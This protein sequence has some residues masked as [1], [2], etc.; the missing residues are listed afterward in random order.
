MIK[1]FFRSN[2]GSVSIYFI[3]TLSA[4][5]L[6]NAV[7]ID[8]ARIKAAEK[9]TEN[10]VRAA[11]RSTLS[12]FDSSLHSYGLYGLADFEQGDD[13]FRNILKRN[14]SD[15]SGGDS[16]RLIQPKWDEKSIDLQPR[17]SLANQEV[18][19]Q[20]VYED[21]KYTAPIEFIIEV[22][23]KF[24]KSGTVSELK[25][26]STFAK[27]AEGLEELIVQREN[28]LDQ[29]WAEAEKLIGPH[30]DVGK[31]Y[32]KYK[33]RLTEINRLAE[34]ITSLEQKDEMIEDVF[35]K[36][37]KYVGLVLLTDQ[38]LQ[39]DY[40]QLNLTKDRIRAHLN[41]AKHFNNQLKT[42]I[43][44]SRLTHGVESGSIKEMSLDSNENIVIMELSFFAQ[45]EVGIANF[46]SLFSGFELRF[47]PAMLT[48]EADYVQRYDRLVSANEAYSRQAAEFYRKQKT[49]EDER[50]R[51]NADLNIMKNDQIAKTKE[52]LKNLKDLF[53]DCGSGSY[54]FEYSQLEAADYS[55]TK[56]AVDLDNAAEIGNQSMNLVDQLGIGLL[57]I[58]DKAYLNE[59]ALSKFN[60]RTQQNEHPNGHKLPKQ[61]AEYILYG[62]NSC[63]LN[64]GAAYAE[65]FALRLATR[66]MEALLNPRGKMVAAGS[67]LLVFMWAVA[68]GAVKAYQDMKQLVNGK[69]VEL[70]EK[71]SKAITINYKDYLRI[72][73]LIH[74]SEENRIARMQGLIKLNT[75]AQL[76]QKAV[77]IEGHATSSIQL[78]FIPGV[79]KIMN[80]DVIGR[81][82]KISKTMILSY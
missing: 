55:S 74:G 44:T 29:A 72:L 56:S 24:Q 80:Y 10:A 65:I 3:I 18:F 57:Q 37:S 6:F 32:R 71:L 69:E 34:Q 17:Y 4:L 12:Q 21:M 41:Q 15:H 43:N 7:L 63:E 64:H 46:L 59:Y 58:R 47:D 31:F 19:K 48:T 20:Q 35:V 60:F 79:M 39:A 76:H 61:E 82:A 27:E 54:L 73:L 52:Q 51:R 67:P 33:L 13:L 28:S 62:L 78:W 5:F 1:Y 49:L 70:T 42:E 8:F 50:T 77:Y 11:L 53:S 22:V 38:S 30:G 2:E 14:L 9:Q 36:I 68:E 16:F 75:G 81:E 25:G 23:N 40:N 45:Y 66:T 26:A